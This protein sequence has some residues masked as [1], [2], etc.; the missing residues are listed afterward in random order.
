V[1]DKWFVIIGVSVC[2]VA[3][4]TMFSAAFLMTRRKIDYDGPPYN[5]P[6]WRELQPPV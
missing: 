3:L 4:V 5:D 6:R 1:S 2:V